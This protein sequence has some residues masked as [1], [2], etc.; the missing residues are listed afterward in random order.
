M[1]V[2]HHAGHKIDIVPWSQ[3]K[4]RELL[5][6]ELS[7]GG[8][9]GIVPWSQR[10]PREPLDRRERSGAK[11]SQGSRLIRSSLQEGALV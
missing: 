2:F 1:L 10:K 8:S 6:K 3:R 9:T 7:S 5:D 11:G 4:P